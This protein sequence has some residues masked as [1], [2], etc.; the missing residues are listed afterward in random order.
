MKKKL[1]ELIIRFDKKTHKPI[2]MGIAKPINELGSAL[3]HL[4]GNPDTIYTL[5]SQ[6]EAKK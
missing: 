2:Y 1:N 6:K 4:Y 5:I 3:K